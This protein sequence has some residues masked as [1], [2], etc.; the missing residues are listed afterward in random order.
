MKYTA[1]TITTIVAISCNLSKSAY[2]LKK[3]KKIINEKKIKNF[4]I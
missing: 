4:E 2:K 1:F 3:D